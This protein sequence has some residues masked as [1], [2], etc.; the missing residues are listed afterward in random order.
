[1]IGDI[2]NDGMPDMV[3]HSNSAIYIM[4]GQTG[5]TKVTIPALFRDFTNAVGIADINKDGFGEIYALDRN[6]WLRAF[7]HNGNQLWR[8]G[9]VPPQQHEDKAKTTIIN[10]CP[11]FL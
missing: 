6:R 3:S 7:D 10:H 4:N 5:K 8:C 9:W 11:I 2:D 1:M